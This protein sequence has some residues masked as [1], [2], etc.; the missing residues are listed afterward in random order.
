MRG[1]RHGF[2]ETVRLARI[3]PAHAGQTGASSTTFPHRPD[4]PR[5]CGAN[6]ALVVCCHSMSGSSPRMRGKLDDL[7][8]MLS[9]LRII[10]AHAGQTDTRVE[11]VHIPA[12][13]PRACGANCCAAYSR[14]HIAGS[15]PR[16]RGKRR[17]STLFHESIRIIPA[18]AGQTHL[19]CRAYSL[20]PDHPRACGA[21][22][23]SLR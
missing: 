6:V 11:T 12:D 15:S 18:H 17:H 13:H 22:E 16:M 9:R 23:A 19:P 5:A 3:I 10:P 7:R 20:C 8:D 4:H 14:C 1:K 2:A 21:N